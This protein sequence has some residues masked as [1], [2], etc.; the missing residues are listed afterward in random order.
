MLEHN[1]L[2]GKELTEL[3]V[4][5]RQQIEKVWVGEIIPHKNHTV[6]Q[7]CRETGEIEEAKYTEHLTFTWGQKLPNKELI[8]TEG[9]DYVSAL[10]KKNALSKWTKGRSGSKEFWDETLKF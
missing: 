1:K 5:K 2:K 9:F 10:N 6:F 3:Q 7:I 4:Q 8:V